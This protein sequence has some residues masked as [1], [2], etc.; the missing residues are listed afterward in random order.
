MTVMQRDLVRE[1]QQPLSTMPPTEHIELSTVVPCLAAL[2]Q[3]RQ[4]TLVRAQSRKWWHVRWQRHCPPLNGHRVTV[5]DA[6]CVAVWW[7]A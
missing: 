6:R 4:P 5:A 3:S 2:L 1:P 7:P